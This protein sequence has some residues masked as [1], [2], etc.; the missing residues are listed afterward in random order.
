MQNINFEKIG[1]KIKE[2]RIS[3]NLTQENIAEAVGVNTSHI[4]NIETGKTK[5]SLT[6]LIF[7][8]NALDVSVDYILGN[9]LNSP[10]FATD[11]EILREVQKLKPDKKEQLLRIT[12]VL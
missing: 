7:I 8:C 1:L 12:K 5:V 6:T 4:S 2:T 11:R 3:R 9:E 10:S